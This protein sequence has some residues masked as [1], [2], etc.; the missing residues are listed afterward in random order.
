MVVKV[1]F[2]KH[3]QLSDKITR[4]PDPDPTYTQ[5]LQ[6]YPYHRPLHE[7]RVYLDHTSTSTPSPGDHPPPIHSQHGGSGMVP[8]DPFIKTYQDPDQAA[9]VISTVPFTT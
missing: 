8:L 4:N 5:H 9:C 3:F 7:G 1:T 6:S 2:I